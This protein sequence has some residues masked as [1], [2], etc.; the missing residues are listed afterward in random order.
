MV[1]NKKFWI[2]Y[3]NSGI[4]VCFVLMILMFLLLAF[5]FPIAL[6]QEETIVSSRPQI[7]LGLPGLNPIIPLWYGI[8]GV[9]RRRCSGIPIP[10][11]QSSALVQR[12]LCTPNRR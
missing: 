7:A 3:A 6:E 8:L 5:T 2:K 12:R 11:F 4:I 1:K 9:Q 10:P